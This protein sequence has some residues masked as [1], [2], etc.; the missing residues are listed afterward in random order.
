MGAVAG[1]VVA[2]EVAR[3][4]DGDAA[5]M[6]AHPDDDQPIRRLN[7]DVVGLGIAQLGDVD[8]LLALDL[9]WCPVPAWKGIFTLHSFDACDC[10][11][12]EINVCETQK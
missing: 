5:E 4:G 11:D 10:F 3:V 9:L 8:R 1:A 6:G 12:C 2:A 7:A